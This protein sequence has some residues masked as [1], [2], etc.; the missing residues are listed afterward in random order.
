MHFKIP[1]ATWRSFCLFYGR[2]ILGTLPKIGLWRAPR[3]GHM[4]PMVSQS[5]SNGTVFPRDYS[6]EYKSSALHISHFVSES[7]GGRRIATLRQIAKRLILRFSAGLKLIYQFVLSLVILKQR[8]TQIEISRILLNVSCYG[9][10]VMRNRI[11]KV[12]KVI[13]TCWAK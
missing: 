3:W 7:T 13:N 11:N 12:V 6:G 4:S 1:Y 8:I 10:M 5:N 9:H 2:H